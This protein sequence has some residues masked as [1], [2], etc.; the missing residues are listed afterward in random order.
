[1]RSL[2]SSSPLWPSKG[3]GLV[4]IIFGLLLVYHGFEI[5]SPETMESYMTW[6][7]FKTPAGR[8]IVYTGKSSEFVA[9]VFITVGLFTRISSLIVLGTFTYITFFIGHGKFWYEDQHP[10]MFWL[11]GLLFLL[12]GPGAWNLDAQIFSDKKE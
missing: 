6:D 7:M 10:F 1:M 8:L 11:F 3:L 2:F 9:G 12:V 5:F 4:R